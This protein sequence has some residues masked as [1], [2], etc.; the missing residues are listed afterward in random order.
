MLGLILNAKLKLLNIEI[1]KQGSKITILLSITI[2]K[3]SLQ[4][5]I[6]KKNY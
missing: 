5:S 6:I 1:D 3:Y 4:Q 2:I